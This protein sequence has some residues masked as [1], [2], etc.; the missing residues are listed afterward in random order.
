MSCS[1]QYTMISPSFLSV[2]TVRQS[3]KWGL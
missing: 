2:L 3:L 1:H